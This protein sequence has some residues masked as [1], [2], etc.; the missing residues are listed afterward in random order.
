MTRKAI[1]LC[2]DAHK[3]GLGAAGLC[4]HRQRCPAVPWAVTRRVHLGALGSGPPEAV[5]ARS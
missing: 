5:T 4:P 1:N 3:Q 2:W